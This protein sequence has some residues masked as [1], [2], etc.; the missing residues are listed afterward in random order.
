[1]DLSVKKA[2]DVLSAACE[3]V[4][5]LTLG[6]KVSLKRCLAED[7]FSFIYLKKVL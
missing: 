3:N 1:M 5:S 6:I 4:E 7:I 2:L